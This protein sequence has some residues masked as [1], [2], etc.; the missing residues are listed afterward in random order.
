[1]D[2]IGAFPPW[3]ALKEG[4]PL[5]C[6]GLP[7][8]IYLHR[9]NVTT[10]Q[11]YAAS[12][13]WSN[14]IQDTRLEENPPRPLNKGEKATI[15]QTSLSVNLIDTQLPSAPHPKFLRYSLCSFVAPL[16]LIINTTTAPQM[17][18]FRLCVSQRAPLARCHTCENLE[19][20][21]G[22]VSWLPDRLV[23]M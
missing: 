6:S 16:H 15:N 19:N 21:V 14:R 12:L 7:P 23:C 4:T 1:M 20:M 5:L 17:L 10:S 11:I 2:R 9:E 8:N 22:D 13:T 18:S 3:A